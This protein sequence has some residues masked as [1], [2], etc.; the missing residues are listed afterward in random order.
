M[1]MILAVSG[2]V[3]SM[4]LLDFCVKKYGAEDVVVAHFNHGTRESCREDEDFI[5][6]CCKNYNVFLEVGYGQLGENV[7]EEKARRKRYEF[8]YEIA[9]KYDGKIATAH[10][11]DD[12]LESI[13]INFLR[14]TGWR[15]VAAMNNPEIFRPFISEMCWGK[16]D[17]LRYAAENSIIFREDPTNSSEKYLRNRIRKE[18]REISSEKR[19]KIFL[20]YSRQCEI[21][22]EISEIVGKIVGDFREIFPKDFISSEDDE[23]SFEILREILRKN[24]INCTRPQLYEAIKAIKNYGNGKK[25]NLP[26]DRFFVVRKDEVE[27][28]YR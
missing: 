7:S 12:L 11:V 1:K 10:H 18:V 27:I 23:V 19:E 17:I 9:K 13:A 8:F 25:F 15:G 28:L 22:R 3:D 20:I 2:G 6:K 4:V 5:K 24:G 16:K 14:G 21:S 26:E